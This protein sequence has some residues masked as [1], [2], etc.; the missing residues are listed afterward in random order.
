MSARV[1]SRAWSKSR[2]SAIWRTSPEHTATAAGGAWASR[3]SEGMRMRSAGA[4]SPR[5]DG[6]AGSRPPALG[7]GAGRRRRGRAAAPPRSAAGAARWPAAPRSESTMAPRPVGLGRACVRATRPPPGPRRGSGATCCGCPPASTT[8]PR[9]RAGGVRSVSTWSHSSRAQS[10]RPSALRRSAEDGPE[11][12]QMRH[13]ADRVGELAVGH[14][15]LQPV[16]E[17]V[18]LGERD[19][20]H[21]VHQS[22]QRRGGHPRN[23]ATICVSNTVAG[24]APQAAMITSRSW[25]DG[26]RNRHAGPAE[27]R[28]ERSRV[29]GER[30]DERHLVRPRDLDQRELGDVGALG[31]ELGVEPVHS[32]RASS[33]TSDCNAASSTI[34]AEGGA[35]ALTGRLR[36]ATS[37]RRR[38]WK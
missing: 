13:V 38:A 24:T 31:V 34:T 35:A 19:P 25:V 14:R 16:R 28:G 8:P 32:S 26:V 12:Q 37:G 1:A 7:P 30:V 29:H 15:A 5:C 20:E 6:L 22:R 18:R 11:L 3:P 10:R 4:S 9:G 17:P 33:A 27:D 2:S 23:P 36:E 21:G